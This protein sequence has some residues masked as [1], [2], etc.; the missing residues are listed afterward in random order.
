MGAVSEFIR[1]LQSY[2]EYAFST[3]EL[4]QKTSAPESSIKK[5]LARLSHNNQILNIRKGF[6]VIIPPRYQHYGRLPLDLYIDK[7]FKVL[8]K[9]Y[10]I[11]FYSAAAYH[12]AAHQ[13]IQQDYVITTPPGLRKIDK[14]STRIRFFKNINWPAKNI[15]QKSSDAGL[16]NLSSPALTFVDLIENQHSLGGLNRMLAI[17]EELTEEVKEEDVKDLL[18]WYTNKS[19][20]QRMGYL[21]D[22]M[23]WNRDLAQLLFEFLQTEKF[24]PTLISPRRGQKAGSTGNRWKI[25]V[26][27]EL[28]S[29]L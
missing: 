24:F 7:L 17:L 9:P 16:F 2:E 23:E 13:Q 29:D 22:E 27:I 26:N 3:E 12:G 19:A 15:I 6:Y 10:Y 5:E 18:D 1:E 20:L 4:M 21:L 11:G 28:E 8:R 14:G 25:D